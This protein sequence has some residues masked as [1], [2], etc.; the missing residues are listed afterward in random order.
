MFNFT[1]R[2][3]WET[4]LALL[5]RERTEVRVGRATDSPLHRVE[6]SLIHASAAVDV[7][8]LAGYV[9]GIVRC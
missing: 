6:S 7:D 4:V 5:S 8:G 9:V 3:V 2:R 1:C